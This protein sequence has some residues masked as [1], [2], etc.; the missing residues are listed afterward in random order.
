MENIKKSKQ[1]DVTENPDKKYNLFKIVLIV[2]NVVTILIILRLELKDGSLTNFGRA[3]GILADNIIWLLI[4][5][6]LL[7]ARIL[8]DTLSYMIFIKDT[9]GEKRFWLAL[10]IGLIGKYG[11][12]VT[13]MATGGQPF[14]IYFLYKYNVDLSTAA[15]I[16]LTRI[17]V[18]V[19]A[20]DLVMLFFFI[21]FPQDAN[22]VVKIF[23]YIGLGMNLLLPTTIF[24]FA[25]KPA[26]VRKL[27]EWG[28]KLGHKLKLVKDI[29]K[30]REYWI[31]KVDDMLN[32]IRYFITHP[33]IFFS[34][35]ILSAIDLLCLASIPYF[36]NRAFGSNSFSWIFIAVS[37]MYVTCSSLLAPTPGTS[38][39]AEASFYAIFNRVIVSGMVFYGL[40][41]W[42]IITFYSYMLIGI[43]LL[44]YESFFK[45]KSAIDLKDISKG[46]ITNKQRAERV[47][48]QASITTEQE[49]Q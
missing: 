43:L 33:S 38:G 4:G 17:T 10:K 42:R 25:F 19:L 21:F 44:I 3:M 28:L 35:F 14:Q 46:R 15:S 7:I 5:I 20:Y 41:T 27:A 22:G 32:S 1:I 39:A 6:G 13:P 26:W 11:D 31:K 34:V 47:S 37:T 49:N 8:A 40:I 12:G 29:D 18:K 23:A 48:A 36:V 45:K 2:I 9:T 30:E 16:P 24:L